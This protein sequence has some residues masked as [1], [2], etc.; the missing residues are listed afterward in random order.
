MCVCVVCV[1]ASGCE[2]ELVTRCI[3]FPC[4]QLRFGKR[5][6]R[7]YYGACKLCSHSV[8]MQYACMLYEH[9]YVCVGVNLY[10]V[11]VSWPKCGNCPERGGV[12]VTS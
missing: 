2:D 8:Y 10:C 4:E 12:G 9:M 5:S 6:P 7:M 11:H 1:C 3:A